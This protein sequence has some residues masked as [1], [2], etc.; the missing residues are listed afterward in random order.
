M[1][2]RKSNKKPAKGGGKSARPLLHPELKG[3]SIGVNSLG[4]IST[5][6]PLEALNEFLD[7]HAPDRRSAQHSEPD[8]EASEGGQTPE[9]AQ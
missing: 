5:S 6:A 1:A 3:F 2:E 8:P 7:R 9:S 4:Q